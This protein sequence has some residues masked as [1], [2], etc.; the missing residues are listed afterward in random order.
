MRLCPETIYRA[1]LVPGGKGLHK[2]YCTKLRTGRKIRRS[3][4]L[5]GP[6]HG[7]AVQN[8]TMIDQRPAEVETNHQVGH[9]EGDLVLGVGCASAM[10]TLRERK[11]HYGIVINLPADHTAQSVNAAVTAAFAPL[12]PHLKRTLTW[13]QGSEMAR[14]L[15]LA[16]ATGVA[17]YFAEAHSPWQRGANENYNGLL[18]QY[19]P[20]GTD[21][22]VHSDAHVAAVMEEINSRPRKSLDY[23]TPAARFRNEARALTTPA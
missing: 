12:P 23:D 8:V 17:I 5:S 10:A 3:R 16:A 20:K 4:W 15:E 1:L 14:H 21:L 22:S 7:G 6:G 2:R 19:F 18:R 11:T 9:W 13:D